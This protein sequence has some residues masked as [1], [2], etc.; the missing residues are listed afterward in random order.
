M[1]V[2]S[3][4]TLVKWS[5]KNICNKVT[6]KLPDDY[7][8]DKNYQVQM[9]HPTAFPLY[10]PGKDRLPPNVR[11]PIPSL[12][13]QVLDGYDNIIDGIR[14]YSIRVCLA[15]WNPGN[16]GNE[17]ANPKSSETAIGGYSYYYTDSAT[18]MYQRNMEGWRDIL[19]FQQVAISEFEKT[20]FIDGLRIVREEGIKFGM[21]TEDGEMWDYY[22]YW[23]SW[24]SFQVE[25]G[26]A[27]IDNLS[28]LKLL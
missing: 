6:L 7:N 11:A 4:D 16:H 25:T 27:N 9:I 8:N 2:K 5:Q 18:Q 20:E 10:V 3:I 19:N 1:I 12:C 23:N 13:V 14:R 22:P 21:F 26:M 24:I 17:I 15:S 28:L